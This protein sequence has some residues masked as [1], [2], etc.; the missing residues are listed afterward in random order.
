[1]QKDPFGLFSSWY[2]AELL[3]N[4][5]IVP[6]ACCLSTLGIDG[7]PNARFVS[8]KEVKDQSFI[9]TGSLDTRK[10]TEITACPKVALT[11]WWPI[12]QKHIRVQGEAFP[13]S[14]EI[15]DNYFQERPLDAQIISTISKT[16]QE[17]KSLDTLQQKFS[18]FERPVNNKNIQ[19]PADWGGYAIKPLRIEFMEFKENRFHERVLYQWEHNHWTT[20]QLQ[21]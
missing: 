9:I 21:P 17:I 4:R 18:S 5:D 12:T 2:A 11:F 13:L 8:L 3:D 7:Y 14:T 20:H 1:M 10:G 16:G 19:R 15:A 6:S